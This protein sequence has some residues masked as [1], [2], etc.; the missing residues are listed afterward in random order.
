M[1][2]SKQLL[3]L[4]LLNNDNTLFCPLSPFFNVIHEKAACVSC[5]CMPA[6]PE[7][8][9]N[10]SDVIINTPTYDV[11]ESENSPCLET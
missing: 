4:R 5:L 3:N 11:T 9:L 2:I 8:F 1:K 7:R 10:T 6:L